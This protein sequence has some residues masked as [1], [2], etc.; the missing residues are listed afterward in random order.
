MDGQELLDCENKNELALSFSE[1]LEDVAPQYKEN[2]L[3]ASDFVL[4]KLDS[5]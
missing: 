5:Q 2:V 4:E 1:F 3:N